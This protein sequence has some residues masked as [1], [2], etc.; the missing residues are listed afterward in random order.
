VFEDIFNVTSRHMEIFASSVR[1]EFGQSVISDVFEPM[2]NEIRALQQMDELFQS[3]SAEID[4]L[5]AELRSI[6]YGRD[7]YE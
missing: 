5:T 2:L 3:R 4:Q 1:D 7:V 6:L